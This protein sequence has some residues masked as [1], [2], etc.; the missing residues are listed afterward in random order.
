MTS[1]KWVYILLRDKLMYKSKLP[2]ILVTFKV[3][4]SS[5][6]DIACKVKV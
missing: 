4:F 1:L 6:S 2:Q 5:F 3:L